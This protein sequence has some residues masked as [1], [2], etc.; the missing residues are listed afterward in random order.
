[1]PRPIVT[2][3]LCLING[4]GANKQTLIL[5]KSDS[6]PL[7]PSFC[8]LS[9]IG[10]QIASTIIKLVR[11]EETFSMVGT[12][13]DTTMKYCM[14][15]ETNLLGQGNIMTH[16]RTPTSRAFCAFISSPLT[17]SRQTIHDSTTQCLHFS[18]WLQ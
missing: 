13:L 1:M 14:K 4:F 5:L 9:L 3:Y 16:Q 15:L 7:C 11:T 2:L 17:P 12:I 6:L 8:I 10:V 18:P